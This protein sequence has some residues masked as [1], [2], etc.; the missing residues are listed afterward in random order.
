MTRHIIPLGEL[1]LHE[2]TR[3]CHCQPYE[4]T[5]EFGTFFFHYSV[6]DTK[7]RENKR[8]IIEKEFE[9]R[10]IIAN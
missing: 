10:G 4:E 8:K 9:E 3:F 2:D 5:N 7:S 6:R 1:R